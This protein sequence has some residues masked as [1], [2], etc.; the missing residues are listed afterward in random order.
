MDY[1]KFES[2]INDALFADSRK[3]LLS[4][5]AQYPE[6]FVGLF[7]PTTPKAKIA[8]SLSQSYEIKFGYAFEKL[9]QLYL[10]E[11][12]CQLLPCSIVIEGDTKE[13]DIHFRKGGVDYVVEQKIRDNHDSTKKVGQID[14]FERKLVAVSKCY[15]KDV[16]GVMFFVDPGMSKNKKFY[17]QR[18][19]EIAERHGFETCTAYGEEFFVMLGMES[20]WGEIIKHLIQWRRELPGFPKFNYD[21][22]ATESFEEIKDMRPGVFQKLFSNEEICQHILPIL[23]PE[24][25]T[26]KM[27]VDYWDSK[28]LNTDVSVL[29]K[30][31]IAK[32]ED[33]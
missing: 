29:V 1:I 21:D 22:N 5:I 20:V 13:L 25:K 31:Q 15:K 6:N 4:S 2:V 33:Q 24:R 11:N 7:R 8:Q 16:K 27:L 23:F 19:S 28:F 32:M 26:L 14:D 10:K 3:K 30:R 9:V 17:E 18:L 12:G